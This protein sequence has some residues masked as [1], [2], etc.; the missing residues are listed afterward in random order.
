L[1]RINAEA[2]VNALAGDAD[3]DPAALHSQLAASRTRMAALDAEMASMR[4][5]MSWRLTAP[6]RLA[7][8]ALK[9]LR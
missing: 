1:H 9:H 3:H 4:R 5:S 2:G 7:A 6:L 8:R